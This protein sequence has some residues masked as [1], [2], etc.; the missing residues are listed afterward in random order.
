VLGTFA[1]WRRNASLGR[2][3]EFMIF[4]A[5]LEGMYFMYDS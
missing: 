4:V 2:I 3:T 5:T 1:T